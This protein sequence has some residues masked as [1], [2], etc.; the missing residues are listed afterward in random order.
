M[1]N[2][3]KKQTQTFRANVGATIVN[4]DGLVLALERKEIPGSWQFP[5]GGL[6]EGEEPMEAVKREILEE[7]GI[8]ASQLDLLGTIPRWLTY[9]FP[10]EVRS[11][12]AW[13]GQVQKWFLFRFNG[14]NE[15]ITMGDGKEFRAWE[16]TSMQELFPKVVS[17]KQ[18][19]YQELGKYFEEY[20]K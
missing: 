14:S 12:K 7:T 3:N 15:A 5:Q 8:E 1:K 10:E 17:F 18:P 19:I 20:L 13:R 16:W 11:Q 9:E 4:T 6:D 2:K